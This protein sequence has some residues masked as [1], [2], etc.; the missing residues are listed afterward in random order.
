MNVPNFADMSMFRVDDEPKWN[1][2]PKEE[3][4][5]RMKRVF[6]HVAN[7]LATTMGPYGSTT[8]IEQFG[9]TYITKDGWAVLK[10]IHYNDPIDNNIMML[11]VR[12]SAQVVAQVGDG[13]TTSIVAAN[14]ILRQLEGN[15]E[16][17]KKYRPKDLIFVLNE[18]V[19][20]ICQEIYSRAIPVNKET[21]EEIGKIAYISTNGDNDI[22]NAIVNIYKET[23]NPSI[24]YV[25]SKTEKTIVE[26]VEGYSARITY[27]DNIFTT[28]DD[29]NCTLNNPY[30]LMFDYKIDMENCLDIISAGIAYAQE[31]KSR[32]V[33]IAPEYDRK[34]LEHI[35]TAIVREYKDRGT[36]SAVYCRVSAI[37]NTSRDLYNDFAIMAGGQIIHERYGNVEFELTQIN[38]FLGHV[39]R[40]VIGKEST[41]ISGFISRNENM[42]KKILDDAI[43][44][45]DT[46]SA[47]YLTRGIIDT[48][49][50]D[51]KNRVAKLHGKMGVIRVGGMSTIEKK[52]NYDLVEDAIKA[53]ESA[54]Q[55]GCNVGGSMIIPIVIQ[56]MMVNKNE[57]E[58][59]RAIYEALCNAFINVFDTIASNKDEGYDVGAIFDDIMAKYDNDG[60]Y[61][62]YDLVKDKLSGDVVN[63]CRTDVEVLRACVSVVSLLLTSNQYITIR[64]Q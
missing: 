42:Y 53:C 7:C 51:V 43:A 37:N 34:L 10:N 39:E 9:E 28:S 22:A 57:C 36:S 8:I 17:F 62:T 55:Y 45:Y 12:I 48:S 35:G 21:L 15:E 6:R 59:H 31:N 54:Y 25:Q 61:V 5:T 32:L 2:I 29:G 49:L 58:E 64:K 20:K 52:A 14:E 11:L 56:D 13:S 3:F 33:V 40:A 26:V 63:S 46:E 38:E 4:K 50:N 18:C 27:I 44:K 19:E 30:L 41:L 23:G 24:E 47:K 1:V 16:I 60:E